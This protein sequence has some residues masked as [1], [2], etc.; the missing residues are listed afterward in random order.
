MARWRIFR[1]QHL[2]GW[3]GS[4]PGIICTGVKWCPNLRKTPEWCLI[5]QMRPIED[6]FQIQW[7]FLIRAPIF[8]TLG[9]NMFVFRQNLINLGL[10]QIQPGFELLEVA[11]W[12]VTI[13]YLGGHQRQCRSCIKLQC[14]F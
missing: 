7:T 6:G 14:F 10:K 8:R 2:N 11:S 13:T 4:E 5:C 3:L 12:K 1:Q 9:S